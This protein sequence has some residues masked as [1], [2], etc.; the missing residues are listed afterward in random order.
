MAH[1]AGRAVVT[2]WRNCLDPR[3]KRL[4]YQG[5]CGDYSSATLA[6]LHRPWR[7]CSSYEAIGSKAPAGK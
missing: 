1:A 3:H 2:D 5:L 6:E 4:F 7:I